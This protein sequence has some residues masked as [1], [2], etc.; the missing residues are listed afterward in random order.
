MILEPISLG[1]LLVKSQ[2][3][4][5]P[6]NDFRISGD[7]RHSN[8]TFQVSWLG[9]HC[10]LNGL[11]RHSSVGEGFWERP[12]QRHGCHSG[13]I[14]KLA[15]SRFF[16]PGSASPVAFGLNLLW[17]FYFFL[18]FSADL[19]GKWRNT[20]ANAVQSH[21]TSHGFGSDRS[22]SMRQYETSCSQ[23]A[24]QIYMTPWPEVAGSVWTGSGA[25]WIASPPQ[26]R[27]P[28]PRQLSQSRY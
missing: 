18:F 3:E 15:T 20:L 14:P 4:S 6:I 19:L 1:S 22:I 10:F 13:L 8:S 26:P 7:P 11:L 27:F 12:I 5:G 28:A 25:S 24:G 23:D 2:A 17:I 16:V 9:I 21:P